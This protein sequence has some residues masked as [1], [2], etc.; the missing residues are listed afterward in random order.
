MY[1][2]N[3]DIVNFMRI[4]YVIFG[5]IIV[6]VL[7]NGC[8]QQSSGGLRAAPSD[9]ITVEATIVSLTRIDNCPLEEE[10]CSVETNPDDFGEIRID[11]IIDYERHP[12]ADYEPLTEG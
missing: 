10:E 2:Y 11:K 7:I 8:T 9:I 6:I 5:L 12:D 4:N 3:Y 1:L